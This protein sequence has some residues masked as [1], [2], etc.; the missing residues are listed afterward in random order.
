VPTELIRN[1]YGDYVAIYFEW[2]NFYIKWLLL[3]G[4]VALAITVLNSMFYKSGSHSPLNGLYSIM[5]ALWGT[6]FVIFWKRRQRELRVKWDLHQSK[7]LDEDVRKEFRG[8]L[9][10]NPISGNKELTFSKA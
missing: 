5:M 6:L 8:T 10:I 4:G 9:R 7:K 2:M 3:P 1:Y